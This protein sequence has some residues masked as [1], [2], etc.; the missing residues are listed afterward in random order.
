MKGGPIILEATACLIVFTSK[1][2]FWSG[3]KAAA[4]EVEK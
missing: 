1:M 3:S 4:S 2:V